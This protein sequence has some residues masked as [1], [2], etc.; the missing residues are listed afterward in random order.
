MMRRLT[1]WLL[2]LFAFS[3]PWEYSLMFAG[4][5]GSIARIFSFAAVFFGLG[6]VLVNG[7]IRPLSLTHWALA[8]FALYVCFSS[9]WA[10]DPEDNF[11]MIR[12]LIQAMWTTWLV[13][14]FADSKRDLRVLMWAFVIGCAVLA[15]LTI[16]D[17]KSVAILARENR[18][19]ADGFNPNEVGRILAWSL[20]VAGG[21]FA[22]SKKW[23]QRWMA[24]LFVPLALFSVVLSGSR[25][26]TLATAVGLVGFIAA[27][28][29]G[30]SGSLLSGAPRVVI[31]ATSLLLSAL[32]VVQF[33]PPEVLERIATTPREISGGTLDERTVIWSM[34]WRAFSQH[35]LL[36]V[37][38]G[39]FTAALG[40]GAELTAHNTVIGIMVE[41]GTIGVVLYAASY[42]SLILTLC[43]GR[44]LKVCMFFLLLCW[45]ISST[46]A[47]LLDSRETWLLMGL[48]LVST[49]FA[50]ERDTPGDRM[51]IQIP[52]TRLN[53]TKFGAVSAP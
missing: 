47:T 24:M 13:W 35:S 23:W 11:T 18:F 29:Q 45:T 9:Y 26:G 7:T 36:G 41:L 31:V 42:L 3:V 33:A 25:G 10:I 51:K 32:V 30:R 28:A 48:M 5:V 4:H 22:E 39:N 8:G 17:F 53:Q 37:G 40:I 50:P 27:S 52:R 46:V 20:P 6:S 21:L 19:A 1:Y 15:T 44:W 14:E 49:R 43:T 38:P 16:R 34:A 12:T 2:V